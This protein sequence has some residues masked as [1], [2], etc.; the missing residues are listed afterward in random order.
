VLS[1][2]THPTSPSHDTCG[3][4]GRPRRY[5]V[6]RI[7]PDAGGH[8]FSEPRLASGAAVVEASPWCERPPAGWW[9]SGPRGHSGPCAALPDT[10]EPEVYFAAR[11]RCGPAAVPVPGDPA[12]DE[13]DAMLRA[14]GLA[15]F[16]GHP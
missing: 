3:T 14:L 2:P 5:A 12:G 9:C 13:V 7:G 11:T 15:T 10:V 8:D 6:H 16:E 1:H 4:C